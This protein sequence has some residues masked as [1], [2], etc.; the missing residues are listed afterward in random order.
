MQYIRAALSVAPSVIAGEYVPQE[1]RVLF[2]SEEEMRL[3]T[4]ASMIEQAQAWVGRNEADGSFKSIIDTYNSHTPLA[5]G[6]ELKYTDEWCAGFVSAVAIATGNTDNVPLEVSCPRMIQIAQNMGIWQENDGYVP[7]PADIILYDWDDSGNGDNTA[8]P[9]HVGIVGSVS[10]GVITVIEGNMSE[11]VGRRSLDVDGRYIRGFITPEYKAGEDN[12]PQESGGK[13][14]DTMSMKF[15]DISNW[16]AGLNVASVVKNGGLGAV[17]VKATEGVGFVDKSCDGFVQQCISNGIR[18][19]FYHFA[20]NNDAAAEAEFFRKNTTGYEGKGIPVLDW[21]DGQSIAWVN[22]FVERYHE[23]TGVWPWVYGNA[24]R[25]NQGT[26]NTNCGR[27]VAGYP[28]N[29]ITDI[30]YGLNNDCAYKVNNGLVCAWQFSS[31]VR[32]SGYS[33]NLDGDVFYGDA[34]AWDKY[35]GGS[36]ASGGSGG[37]TTTP[38]G[39][40]LSLAVG[41]MQGKY[42]NGT[43]RKQA[44]GSRYDEVQ[45]FIN[46]ISTASAQTLAQEVLAG[47]YGNGDTRK[48]VLGSRYNEVQAIVNQGG[49][50]SIDEVAREVIRGEWGNGTARKQKLEA[51]GYD[52]E[53]VQARV[54]ALL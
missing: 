39:S 48:T 6:Y 11:K 49:K 29:G 12:E 3:N 26:V 54:N 30:N 15:I 38:S 27:W 9:D 37:S 28:S 34:A 35:A 19:G 2:L 22:K 20:R 25:F 52:Y 32:I 51:A 33:G 21:E 36:P 8:N 18:F 14:E 5:R 42:G 46:H 41:V 47:K 10:D 17:I 45:D 24:W 13:D 50:K 7:S 23:L 40:V 44:L 4:R 43:A 31:S 53:T 16:Q 1:W